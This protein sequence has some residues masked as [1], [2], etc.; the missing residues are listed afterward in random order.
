MVSPIQK[1]KMTGKI[2]EVKFIKIKG[3]N[4]SNGNTYTG[5]FSV[6]TDTRAKLYIIKALD[7]GCTRD[8]FDPGERNLEKDA[9]VYVGL[10]LIQEMY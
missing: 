9:L 6:D 7:Q 4:G 2:D 3:S 5:R 1:L 8:I 10:G